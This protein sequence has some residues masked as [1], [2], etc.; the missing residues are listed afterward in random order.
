MVIL[1]VA[2]FAV[3]AYYQYPE[4]YKFV[5]RP[6]SYT[7]KKLSDGVKNKTQNLGLEG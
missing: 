3:S 6:V 1:W 5:A 7:L 2:F 4:L